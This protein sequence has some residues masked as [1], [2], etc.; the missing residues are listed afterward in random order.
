MNILNQSYVKTVLIDR[1]RSLTPVSAL[2]LLMKSDQY[3]HR[4]ENSLFLFETQDILN[5]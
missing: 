3:V 2:Q 1:L 5:I 4:E